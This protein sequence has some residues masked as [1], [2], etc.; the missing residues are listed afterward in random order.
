[1]ALGRRPELVGGKPTRASGAWFE[2]KSRRQRRA[3]EITDQRI[4]GSSEFVERIL[5][6]ADARAVRQHNGN[7]AKHDAERVV[8]TACKKDWRVAHRTAKRKPARATARGAGDVRLVE[9]YGVSVAEVARQ[10][11]ISTS[12]VS[13]ILTRSLSI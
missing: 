1:M 2:V 8:A 9:K 12:G 13:K 4:L 10:I 5:R 3:L 7:K 6:E 11:G